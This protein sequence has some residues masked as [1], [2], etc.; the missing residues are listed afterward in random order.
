MSPFTS[1]V[2]FLYPNFCFGCKNRSDT[3]GY[4]C[5]ACLRQ[6]QLIDSNERCRV[7]FS[8]NGKKKSDSSYIYCFHCQTASPLFMQS[9]LFEKY[10]LPVALSNWH[11]DKVAKLFAAYCVIQWCKMDLELPDEVFAL[12]DQSIGNFLFATSFMKSIAK[13]FLAIVKCAEKSIRKANKNGKYNRKEK[14]DRKRNGNRKDK[15]EAVRLLKKLETSPRPKKRKT[16]LVLAKTLD[17][18]SNLVK[19][20]RNRKDL[21]HSKIHVLALFDRIND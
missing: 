17:E 18:D 16:I 9:A 6:F 1:F 8:P 14:G 20:I 13:E 12:K 2:S 10:G 15:E 3:K 21:F 5:S 7:C 11:K 19:M 4:I